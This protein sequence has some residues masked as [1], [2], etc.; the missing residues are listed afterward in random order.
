MIKVL[1]MKKQYATPYERWGFSLK[2]WESLALLTARVEKAGIAVT[3]IN[4]LYDDDPTGGCELLYSRGKQAIILSASSRSGKVTVAF[5]K[6]LDSVA[7]Q[8]VCQGDLNGWDNL[9]SQMIYY[10]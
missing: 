1:P 10:H 5:H 4:N 2:Q 7:P 6:N 3:G 9:A 8:R